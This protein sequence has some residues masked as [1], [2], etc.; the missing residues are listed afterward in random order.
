MLTPSPMLPLIIQ[1]SPNHRIT[2]IVTTEARRLKPYMSHLETL[3]GANQLWYS[4]FGQLQL[5][6]ILELSNS[7][8]PKSFSP[9]S[10]SWYPSIYNRLLLG[11]CFLWENNFF[12][13]IHE[14]KDFVRWWCIW[15]LKVV[16]SL[17]IDYRY[18]LFEMIIFYTI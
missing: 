16:Q 13:C 18:I 14:T 6:Y 17:C 12:N 4:D 5:I 11:F 15:R 3:E 10:I 9:T 1:S 8:F 7:S 2:L